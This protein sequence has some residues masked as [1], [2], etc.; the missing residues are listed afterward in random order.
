M[1][2]LSALKGVDLIRFVY[3]N[4]LCPKVKRLGK[5]Y[6]VPYRNTVIDMAEDTELTLH[7]GHLFLNDNKPRGAHCE[8]YLV[9]KKGARME[10]KGQLIVCTRVTLEVQ[11]KGKLTIG[12]GF[13]NCDSVINVADSIT[14]GDEVLLARGV[15]IY[16]SDHHKVLD[17]KGNVAN[18][19]RPVIIGDH[20]WLAQNCIILKGC[21]IGSG[22]VLS[23]GSV[24]SGRLKAGYMAQGNPARS[25]WP[26]DWNEKNNKIME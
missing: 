20:V 4:F 13:F 16:D 14:L 22:A 23:A 7:D 3:Y 2:N 17:E 26:I 15:R 12:S 24:A 9:M 21:K 8:C 19:P 11:E 18:P 10:V 1:H 5:G 25:F 6:L